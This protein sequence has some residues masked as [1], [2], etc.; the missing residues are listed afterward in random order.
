[1]SYNPGVTDISGQLLGAG[2]SQAASAIGQ[3]IVGYKQKVDENKTLTAQSKALETLIPTYAQ[4]TGIPQDQIEQALQSSPDESPRQRYARLSSTL[5]GLVQVGTA[6]MQA[7]QRDAVGTNIAAE[8]QRMTIQAQ[9]IQDSLAERGRMRTMFGG[10]PSPAEMKAMIDGGARFEELSP[11]ANPPADGAAAVRG[12]LGAGIENP[13][14]LAAIGKYADVAPFKPTLVDLGQGVTGMMT[15]PHSAIP[16]VKPAAQ[17]PTPG[18][19][20]VEVIDLPGGNTIVRDVVT[21]QPLPASVVV[22]AP[23]QAKLDPMLVGTISEQIKALEAEKLQHQQAMAQGDN[24]YGLLNAH[25]RQDRVAEIDSRLSGLRA[26]LAAGKVGAA[27]STPA[28]ATPPKPAA[29]V[30]APPTLYN[31]TDVQAE[32]R[33]RGLIK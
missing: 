6:K 30:K 33:R 18:T 21:K 4:A 27:P 3:G 19:N 23:Q 2:I 7:M 17:R 1:M 20:G 31:H 29:P 24:R 22:K 32:L 16:V 11:A 8:K 13:R 15:S 5:E 28:D 12:A 14:L 10:T 26:T 25:R 9:E